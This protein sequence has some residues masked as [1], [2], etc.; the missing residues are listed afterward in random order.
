MCSV[1]HPGCSPIAAILYPQAPLQGKKPG[2]SLME[3]FWSEV[4][5]FKSMKSF[6]FAQVKWLLPMGNSHPPTHREGCVLVSY[7]LEV[8]PC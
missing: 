4:L 7:L 6:C 5:W 2:R 3:L 8:S 1:P